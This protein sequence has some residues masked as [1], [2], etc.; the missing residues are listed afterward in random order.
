MYGFSVYLNEAI[1]RDRIDRMVAAGFTGI[2]HQYIFQKM[3]P[4]PI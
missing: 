2:L 1:D 4:L 3:I